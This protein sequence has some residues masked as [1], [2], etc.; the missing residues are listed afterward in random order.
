MSE[1]AGVNKPD[2][3]F[4][5]IAFERTNK[6]RV[7]AGKEPVTKDEI[8]LIGDGYGSDIAGAKNFVIDQI[9]VCHNE[10][11][12]NDTTKTA[13]YKVMN[14]ADVADIL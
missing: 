2:K 9:Y 5:D 4:F 13:T 14:L 11:T 1:E 6:A 8:I 12:L 7:A 10:Q 3:R